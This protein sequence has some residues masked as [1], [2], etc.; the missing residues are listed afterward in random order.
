MQIDNIGDEQLD[1]LGRWRPSR[2][3]WTPP[4]ILRKAAHIAIAPARAMVN[5]VVAPIRAAVTGGSIKQAVEES[6]LQ[7][8]G[9][10]LEASAPILPFIPVYGNI[11][12][13]ILALNKL[14]Q[15]KAAMNDKEREDA[16]IDEQIAKQEAEVQRMESQ[17]APP[18]SANTA[19]GARTAATNAQLPE[20]KKVP[21]KL[22][23][24]GAIMAI[25]LLK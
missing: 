19:V 8:A 6:T 22:L 14:R 9:K 15:M 7:P 21:W 13:G 23:A 16:A 12:A 25:T 3:S 20:A 18:L 1:G 2:P 10:L 24:S 17:S 11:A 5:T 4:A